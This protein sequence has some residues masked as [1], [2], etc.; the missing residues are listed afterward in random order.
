M[1]SI[2]PLFTEVRDQVLAELDALTASV[3]ALE[4][5]W[6]HLRD[7]PRRT[8]CDMQLEVPYLAQLEKWYT[9]DMPG[10]KAALRARIVN[11]WKSGCGEAWQN[12]QLGLDGAALQ[13]L[14]PEIKKCNRK[15]ASLLPRCEAA[16][17]LWDQLVQL[18]VEGNNHVYFVGDQGAHLRRK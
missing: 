18:E 6:Q 3:V 7:D 16:C 4:G 13:Q 10:T 11:F 9:V 12:L 14:A 2:C 8:S 15:Y 5:Q 17:E 1:P